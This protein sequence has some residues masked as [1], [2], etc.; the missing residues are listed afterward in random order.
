MPGP[1]ILMDVLQRRLTTT[2][3]RAAWKKVEKGKKAPAPSAGEQKW[4]RAMP[5]TLP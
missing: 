2:Q 1:T 4:L 5:F 3:A